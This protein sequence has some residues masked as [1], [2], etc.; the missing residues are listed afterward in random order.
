M[1]KSVLH[2]PD[3]CRQQI[4]VA[5]GNAYP[6]ECCGLLEG[7]ETPIGWRVDVVH[8]AA[9]LAETPSR[10][11]LID[12]K[13]QFHLLRSLRGSGRRIIGCFHSHP[14]GEAMPSEEDRRQ[15]RET[16]FLWLIAGGAG[17]VQLNAFLCEAAV[18]LSPVR[19]VSD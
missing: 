16:G 19:V 7:S 1:P 13:L 15:A 9:N 3:P 4:L 18:R 8:E 2:L 17:M 5:A 11:F 14:G 6:L 12:P 10:R